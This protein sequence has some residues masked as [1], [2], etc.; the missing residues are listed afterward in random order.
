MRTRLLYN[1]RSL[2]WHFTLLNAALALLILFCNMAVGQVL[3]LLIISPKYLNSA[4]VFIGMPLQW[5]SA[6]IFIYMA[7][8]LVTFIFSPF[9]LQNDINIFS[10]CYNP[11]ALG[12][13]RTASSANARRKIDKVAISKNIRCYFSTFYYSRYYNR[14]GYTWSN[15]ILNNSGDA[16]SPYLTP[17]L[18][19][20]LVY[21][22]PSMQILP[23]FWTYMFRMIWTRSYGIPSLVAI[24]SHKV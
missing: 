11:S 3:A 16:P 5:N 17:V 7:L 4:T 9:E 8:V 15:S 22:Y 12:E 20:K 23:L 19:S 1:P 13:T 14:A 6:S 18:A 24:S 10:I 21:Y 2:V